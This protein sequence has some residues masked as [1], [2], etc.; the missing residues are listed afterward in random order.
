[1]IQQI[2]EYTYLWNTGHYMYCTFIVYKET[3]A[4]ICQ[5]ALK[6]CTKLGKWRGDFRIN[7]N[8]DIDLV[9]LSNTCV[10]FF[11]TLFIFWMFIL[12]IPFCLDLVQ[13]N[14]Y[15]AVATKLSAWR[16][17]SCYLGINTV[18]HFEAWALTRYSVASLSM[19]L[20]ILGALLIHF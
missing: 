9:S 3:T 5:T 19:D 8:V 14:M 18:G 17:V 7:P 2:K 10:V 13:N 15:R 4:F 20:I 16:L 11:R 6:C 12:Y 1:M